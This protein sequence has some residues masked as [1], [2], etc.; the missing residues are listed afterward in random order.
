MKP[1]HLSL[2]LE[3]KTQKKANGMQFIHIGQN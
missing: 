1:I 3:S 2:R